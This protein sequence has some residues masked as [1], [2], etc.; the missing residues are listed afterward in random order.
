MGCQPW[1]MELDRW[2]ASTATG[3]SQPRYAPR[4]RS[5]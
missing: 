4:N 5:R 2:P 3:N 1:A